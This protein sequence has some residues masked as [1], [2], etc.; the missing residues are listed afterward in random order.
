MKG[1]A[2]DY[3]KIA[4]ERQGKLRFRRSATD[5]LYAVINGFTENTPET[6]IARVAK[7]FAKKHGIGVQPVPVAASPSESGSQ[8]PGM[9][10]A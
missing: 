4:E 3:K 5:D 7:D 1:D 2:P 10:S 8:T 9:T 6:V